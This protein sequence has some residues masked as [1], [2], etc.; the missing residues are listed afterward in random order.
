MNE[1]KNKII[2]L[3]DAKVVKLVIENKSKRIN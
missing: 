1:F 2:I 3:D